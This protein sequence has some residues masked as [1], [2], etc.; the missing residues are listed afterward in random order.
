MSLISHVRRMWLMSPS[1]SNVPIASQLVRGRLQRLK[2]GSESIEFLPCIRLSWITCLLMTFRAHLIHDLRP[3]ICT[4]EN[5]RTPDQLY[6]SKTDWIE[7]ET[8]NHA[9]TWRCPIHPKKVF[10]DLVSFRLHGA[11][12]HIQYSLI[13]GRGE[14]AISMG[15]TSKTS[16][17]CPVCTVAGLSAP[18][19]N[20]HVAA[21]LERFAIFSLP[22]HVGISD[23]DEDIRG[24]D[25][26]NNDEDSRGIDLESSISF[27]SAPRSILGQ[28][29]NIEDNLQSPREGSSALSPNK[30]KNQA[31]DDSKLD[32]LPQQLRS[33][34]R[35]VFGVDLQVLYERDG[36]AVPKFVYECIQAIDR[37]GLSTEGIYRTSGQA[38]VVQRLRAEF[39]RGM[40]AF[41]LLAI[42]TRY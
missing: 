37:F 42:R 2:H 4:Y 32:G 13:D 41:H 7:H 8:A 9:I 17:S 3:Y 28:D 22:Q 12:G 11:D 29:H 20:D 35:P 36:D 26:A 6:D 38:S 1:F 30:G 5:C 19:L 25:E 27:D 15:L 14:T 34:S 33:Q 40:V 10:G 18:Q 24:S 23:A 16:R 31:Q 21:H 39:D